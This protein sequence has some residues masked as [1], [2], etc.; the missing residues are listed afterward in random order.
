KHVRGSNWSTYPAS[1]HCPCNNS[2]STVALDR[3]ASGV[4]PEMLSPLSPLGEEAGV[5]GIFLS[6]KSRISN[7]NC[8]IYTAQMCSNSYGKSP[9]KINHFCDFFGLMET[10]TATSIIMKPQEA[11]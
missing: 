3:P 1:G 4:A 10:T 5:R 8:L 6:P 11:L 7:S 2:R 9:R